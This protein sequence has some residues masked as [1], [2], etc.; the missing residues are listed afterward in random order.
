MDRNYDI[1]TQNRFMFKKT[2]VTNFAN[3]IKIA[4]ILIKTLL[5]DLKKFKRIRNYVLKCTLYICTS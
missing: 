3:N 4:V 1:I 5:K 2:G